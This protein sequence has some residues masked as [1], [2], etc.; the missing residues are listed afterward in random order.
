MFAKITPTKNS[1]PIKCQKLVKKNSQK[2]LIIIL[3]YFFA[4]IIKKSGNT[5]NISTFLFNLM[6]LYFELQHRLH[7]MLSF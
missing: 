5:K 1:N 4:K 2:N 6:V 3:F 7:I